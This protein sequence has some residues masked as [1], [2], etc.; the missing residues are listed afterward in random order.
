MRQS[1]VLAN[2]ASGLLVHSPIDRLGGLDGPLQRTADD[3]GQSD[4]CQALRYRL[5]LGDPLVIK[6]DTGCPSGEHPGRIGL[7]ATMADEDGKRHAMTVPNARAPRGVVEAREARRD[8]DH[9]RVPRWAPRLLDDPQRPAHAPGPRTRPRRRTRPRGVRLRLLLGRPHR[10][11]GPGGGTRGRR[12]RPRASPARGRDVAPAAR[13]TRDW[14]PLA[15]RP[16]QGPRVGGRDLRRR[17]GS[18]GLL[19]RSGPGHHHA[20]G[21]RRGHRCRD[22]A[23]C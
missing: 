15:I 12:I 6:M 22:R 4:W 20:D 3:G 11:D 13:Q 18:G 21:T 9:G 7:R 16:A 8:P 14:R 17:N 23:S 2:S 1:G 10:S 19:R 5:G